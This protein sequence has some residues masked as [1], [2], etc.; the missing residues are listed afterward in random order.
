MEGLNGLTENLSR[1]I[2]KNPTLEILGLAREWEFDEEGNMSRLP[3]SG[4]RTTSLAL[5]HVS[6]NL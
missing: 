3:I 5:S 6:P 4:T 1:L 2:E